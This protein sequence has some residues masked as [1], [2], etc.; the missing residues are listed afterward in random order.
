MLKKIISTRDLKQSGSR[1]HNPYHF[2][3]FSYIFLWQLHSCFTSL[4]QR[5]KTNSLDLTC[6][7]HVSVAMRMLQPVSQLSYRE[8]QQNSRIFFKSLVQIFI[9]GFLNN[10]FR[11]Q[12]YHYFYIHCSLTLGELV[13]S[14]DPHNALFKKNVTRRNMEECE[15]RRYQKQQK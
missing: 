1:L 6:L 13:V 12:L 10:F 4:I 2:P 14:L 5:P 7:K 8:S 11:C 9:M 15:W 3:W